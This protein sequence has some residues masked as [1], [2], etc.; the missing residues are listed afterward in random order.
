[1]IRFI[2]EKFKGNLDSKS[3]KLYAEL[4]SVNVQ[5]R[6]IVRKGKRVVAQLAMI[7]VV[8]SVIEGKIFHGRENQK[9]IQE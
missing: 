8:K 2:R 5:K 4:H 3:R 9:H 6:R 1:M 7:K